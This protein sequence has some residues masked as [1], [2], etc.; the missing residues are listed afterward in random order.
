[1]CVNVEL[2]IHSLCQCSARRVIKCMLGVT[3][4]GQYALFRN[5]HAQEQSR[6]LI[7]LEVCVGSG[8]VPIVLALERVCVQ[9]QEVDVVLGLA[10]DLQGERSSSQANRADS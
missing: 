10:Q 1:M 4:P 8:V 2:A 6:H 3:C 9:G 5:G 7:H